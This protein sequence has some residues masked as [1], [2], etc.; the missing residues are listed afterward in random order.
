MIEVLKTDKDDE[1]PT[2]RAP[3][4]GC[5]DTREYLASYACVHDCRYIVL[6]DH[7]SS[8]FKGRV[9]QVVFVDSFCAEPPRL[10]EIGCLLSAPYNS[11]AGRRLASL[12]YDSIVYAHNW[13]GRVTVVADCDE[14][15]LEDEE[16]CGGEIFCLG[17]LE[18]LGEVAD[19]LTIVGK[20]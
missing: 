17:R 9:Y 8:I 11:E 13:G 16:P 4:S 5:R 6:V 7:V 1:E 15:G 19:N 12:S 18:E 3:S 20:D 2:P 14:L 10:V